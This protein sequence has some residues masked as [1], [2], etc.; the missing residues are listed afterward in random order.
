MR[1]LLEGRRRPASPSLVRASIGC[2]LVGSQA[3]HG[4]AASRRGRYNVRMRRL[5]LL[6]ALLV[7][8]VA[9][10]GDG[11]L[12]GREAALSARR[13]GRLR[14]HA[15]RGAGALRRRARPRRGGRRRR[16]VR[17]SERALRA[18]LLARGRAQVARAEALDRDDGFRSLGSARAAAAGRRGRR[19]APARSDAGAAARRGCRARERRRRDLGA[20]PEHRPLRGLPGGDALR[21]RVDGQARRARRRPACLTAGRAQP[22]VVRRA[23]DRLLV[24]QPGGEPAPRRGS[25]TARSPT[26]CVGSA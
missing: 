22:L 8:A 3:R 13:A 11:G 7:P 1:L 25:A 4:R 5:A 21:G 12:A 23:P 6:L 15:R 17:T 26:G 2:C 14:E 10:G 16:P 9:H 24:V 19:P 18:D 20:R